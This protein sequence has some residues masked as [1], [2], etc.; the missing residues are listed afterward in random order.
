MEGIILVTQKFT[1]FKQ[2][3]FFIFSWFTSFPAIQDKIYNNNRC[4]FYFPVC[5]TISFLG[6]F[7]YLL[8]VHFQSL[9]VS[10]QGPCHGLACSNQLVAGKVRVGSQASH[11]GFVVNKLELRQTSF[12]CFGFLLSVTVYK[13]SLF[14]NM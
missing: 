6:V 5:G 12:E 1:R 3:L 8:M 14:I 13:L 7:S 9:E 10:F 2:N 4:L 11:V